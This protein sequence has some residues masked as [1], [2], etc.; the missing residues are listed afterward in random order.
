MKLGTSINYSG[1]RR[2]GLLP[3]KP[4]VTFSLKTN[5]SRKNSTSSVLLLKLIA[6][7]GVS[8][9]PNL[10]IVKKN[11]KRPNKTLLQN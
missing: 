11:Q 1:A 2:K 9:N 5:L 6:A 7:T 3:F 8:Q 4:T 10:A